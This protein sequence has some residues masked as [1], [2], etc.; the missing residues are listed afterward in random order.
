MQSLYYGYYPSP[1]GDVE[2]TTTDDAVVSVSFVEKV[3]QSK[4]VPQIM[5][6]ALEQLKE[7]FQG[8]RKVFDL[9]YQLEGTD[10]Q[11][12]TWNA[13]LMIPY[14]HTMSYKQIA[15]SIGNVKAT[16]AVGGANN[17]NK[18][19]IMIPCH[20]VIGSNHRLV[21]YAGG[22]ERK[23]W[24]LAHEQQNINNN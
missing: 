19:A 5:Q 20:R 16:R 7:Y 6:N 18:I 23:E 4:E 1:I 15:Q 12:K 21:G 24:L 3:R 10:F 14:G 17:K 8:T 22:L 2:I 13:L 11:V 9:T